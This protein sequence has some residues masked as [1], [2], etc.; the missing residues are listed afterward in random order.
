[1]DDTDRS[2]AATDAPWTR[3]GILR[4]GGGSLA[5]TTL[6]ASGAA[7]R[8]LATASP[9]TESGAT[10]ARAVAS[11]GDLSVSIA[12]QNL[13]LGADFLSIARDNDE[14]TVPE[15]VGALY[16]D[17]RK[18]RPRER[19]VAI[20]Q[21]LTQRRPAIVGVQEAA[22]VRRGP[23]TGNDPESPDADGIV[24][25][26]LDALRA[27][28][29]AR[30]TPYRPVAV[31]TNADLEFP[32]RVDGEAIDVRLTDRD[33]ILVREDADVTVQDTSTATFDA[34]LTLPLSAERSVE[35]ER[36]YARADLRVAGEPLSVLN[37]HLESALESV[38]TAQATE[39]ASA[40]DAGST[41]L[42]ALGDFNDGPDGERDAY[43]ILTE[44]L[45]DV[46]VEG[47]SATGETAANG[48]TA[49]TPEARISGTCCRPS[50]LR[51]PDEDGLTR[52]IDHVFV[53]GIRASHVRRFGVEAVDVDG[54]TR[55]WPSDHAGVL[56]ALT[57]APA[58]TP[59]A[60]EDATATVE[61]TVANG[62]ATSESAPTSPQ[63][64]EPTAKSAEA[65]GDTRSST[66]AEN[67][68]FG[69]VAALSALV[70]GA[71]GA[72]LLD[73]RREA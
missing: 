30:E 28:L 71:A 15:R 13:G 55:R 23:R 73:R 3:R 41:P 1:M 60:T 72:A 31:A 14:A 52:R 58:E 51:P 39:F 61:G 57:T 48:S 33:A 68:G 49:A 59:T 43:E 26:F 46:A 64:V 21:E 4:V 11:D 38:R 10:G 45:S 2:A 6:L 22:I 16:T 36:G 25:D 54:A 18:S 35:I 50:S 67:P 70:G 29:R 17:V 44:T 27:A 9:D 12:T 24:F 69:V 34:S 32:G 5:A 56:A 20:A 7:E 37:T 8:S 47:T 42:V 65:G 62:S 53:D 19:M 63:T 40:V 66:S